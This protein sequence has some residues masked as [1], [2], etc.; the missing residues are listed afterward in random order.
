MP[1]WWR[2]Y[3][4]ICPVSWTLYGLVIS[5]YGDM[6]DMLDNGV[7]VK[8]FLKSYFGFEHKFLGPVAGIVTAF[9]ILFGLIFAVSI[10]VFNFQKR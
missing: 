2:W 5:Q 4:Y 1:V 9:V 6:D 7:T 8:Q 3:Y 10:K